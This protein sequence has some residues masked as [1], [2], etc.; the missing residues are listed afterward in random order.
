MEKDKE[1]KVRGEDGEGKLVQDKYVPE[2]NMTK[3]SPIANGESEQSF[4]SS[5][6]TYHYSLKK[7]FS[8]E[9]SITHHMIKVLGPKKN[10]HYKI[11]HSLIIWFLNE[12]REANKACQGTYFYFTWEKLLDMKRK[13]MY[14]SV[15]FFLAFEMNCNGL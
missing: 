3:V 15:T 4:F 1:K 7:A 8:A 2:E 13:M 14:E 10:T 12:I 11:L 5:D 6:K 9:W